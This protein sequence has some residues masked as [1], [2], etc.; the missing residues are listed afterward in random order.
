MKNEK[1]NKFQQV[2]EQYILNCL[3]FDDWGKY[4]ESMTDKEKVKT[5][6][7]VFDKEFNYAYN[8]AKYKAL[9]ARI[10]QYIRGLPPVC[11]VLYDDYQISEFLKANFGIKN[12]I[13][14]GV[15]I[16]CWFN[17]VANALIRLATKNNVSI[18]KYL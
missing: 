6:F 16:G 15:K 14:L 17:Y 9:D 12:D 10:E 4:A 5:F 7:E 1:R 13:I 18:K 3:D 8:K 2:M 11:D